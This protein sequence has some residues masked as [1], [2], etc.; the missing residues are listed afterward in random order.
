MGPE[1]GGSSAGVP[2][3]YG[4]SCTNCSRAKCKCVL[5]PATNVCQRCS[6]LGK[7]CQPMTATRK[8]AAKKTNASRTAQLEEKLDDLVSILRASQNANPQSIPAGESPAFTG[9]QALTSRLDSL[10]AAA[11]SSTSPGMPSSIPQAFDPASTAHGTPTSSTPPDINETYQLPEPTPAEA[12]IYLKKFRDWLPNFPFMVLPH[13]VTAESLRKERPFLWLCIMNITTMSCPQN[14][15]LKE[16]VRQE[17]AQRVIVNNERNMDVLLGLI[18]YLAWA[19]MSSGPGTRPFIIM[20]SQIATAIIYELSLSRA[21]I[22][23]QYFTICFKVWGGRPPAPKMRSME[24]RRAVLALWFLT[25]V[26]ASFIGKMETLRWTPHM[27]DCL[28]VLERDCEHPSDEILVTFV[29]YQQVA[30]E[31]QKLLL[32]DV[33]GE[34]GQTPTHVFKKGM[35]AKIQEIQENI[36]P[37]LMPSNVLRMQMLGTEVQVHS[38]GLFLQSIPTHQRIESM[39]G[40]LK[41]VR[42]WYEI[43]LSV[44]LLEIPGS[45]FSVYVQLSQVQVALYRLTTSEDPAWDKDFVRNTA[46]MLALLDQTIELF[47]QLNAAYPFKV[48][49]GED[50]L[51]DKACKIMKNIRIS[52]EPALSRHL[53]GIPTPNSQSQGQIMPNPV[54]PVDTG[55][56]LHPVF[57]LPDPNTM[58]FGDMTWMSDVFGPWEF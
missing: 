49:E 9:S 36:P 7:E 25:S 15:I 23:E 27:E 54:P 33:M 58:N 57:N 18:C 2:A 28:K 50:T 20:Y 17:I 8:R 5:N 56:P 14:A 10:A 44:P 13:D 32:Q 11:T 31:A 45:P 22:E 40:C 39:F 16:R 41:A 46:D 51:F 47:G 43:F 30:E 35:L 19:T 52:W 21:P 1:D 24:E 6:R 55:L 37:G 42:E 3:R 38:V 29:R 12:E 34:T 53:G 4:R 48:T 26:M